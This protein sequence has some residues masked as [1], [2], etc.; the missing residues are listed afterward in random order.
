MDTTLNWPELVR[1]AGDRDH[2]LQLYS[3][4]DFLVESVVRY[5]G[6]G[7]AGG[8]AAIIIARPEHRERFIRGL[9]REGLHPSG[10]LRFLDA[11]TTLAG[12]LVNGTP[13]WTAFH[14]TLGGAIAELRLRYRSVRAYGEMVD[15]LWQRGQQRAALRLEE[16]WNELGCLQTFSL[17]C[18]YG[19]DPLEAASYGG[20]ALEAVC[21]CHTHLIPAR[22]Y[23]RFNDAVIDASKEVL[24]QPLAQMLL[25]LAASTRLQTEMPLGQAA[26]IWLKH[27]MPRT[28]DRVL[29][30]VRSRLAAGAVQPVSAPGLGP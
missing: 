9:A 16:F 26:L 4:P 20:G 22:D 10:A 28:A 19:I 27:N 12:F 6:A 18:A 24:D 7:L 17:L 23:G 29:Q 30:E 2:M 15:I 8:E 3:D 21:K 5:V 11:E 1:H 13:E 25:S 14:R